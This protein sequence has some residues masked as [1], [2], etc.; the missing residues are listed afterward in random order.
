MANIPHL[1]PSFPSLR[2]GGKLEVLL[3]G[4]LVQGCVS[5]DLGIFQDSAKAL[6]SHAEDTRKPRVPCYNRVCSRTIRDG[7]RRSPNKGKAQPD[8]FSLRSLGSFI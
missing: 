3:G 5:C 2:K 4:H 1:L 8:Y 7:P 6:E